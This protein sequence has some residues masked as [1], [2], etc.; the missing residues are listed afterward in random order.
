[1]KHVSILVP[2]AAVLASIDDPR[3][4]FTG[5]NN[6]LQSMQLQPLFDVQLVG[7]T[8]EVK[9]HDARFT[10]HTD[11]LLP[12]VA[13]TDLIIIPALTG[14][15]EASVSL[16]RDFIPWIIH[17]YQNG[18]ELVSLCSGAFFLAS[19]GLLTGKECSTHWV[20]TNNF[21][22]LF[23][24]VRLVDGKI[25]T[26]QDGIYTSG[27]ATSYWN[28]L[29]YL[30]EKHVNRDMAILAAK[31]FAI[32]LDRSSQLSYAMFAGQ[33]SHDDLPIRKA[34]E[35]IE[36]NY[37]QRITIDHLAT[38]FA[39][40][41]RNFERRFKKATSNTVVEYIQRVK[42]EAAKKSLESTVHNV[43]EVIYNAGYSDP[44]AFRSAFKRITGLSPLQYRSKFTKTVIVQDR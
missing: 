33:K 32:D 9:L 42:I 13:K 34:Q 37:Q 35:Y 14:D 15:M 8:S 24:D 20:H 19:T 7:L 43:N 40:G 11:A 28:L 44:K 25:I 30:V 23:P 29:L 17:Q 26:E 5:V 22:T 4:M 27:G 10:V 16:N 36:Q 12:T 21:R 1:M 39:I 18:A 38:T 2:Q 6:F 3:I 31:F 41:R